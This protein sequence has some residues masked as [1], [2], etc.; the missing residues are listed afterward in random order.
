M[1]QNLFV[2]VVEGKPISN[3]EVQLNMDVMATGLWDVQPFLLLV[4]LA[5]ALDENLLEF[6][7]RG[8]VGEAGNAVMHLGEILVDAEQALVLESTRF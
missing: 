8:L 5:Q 7:R 6:L 2:K 3:S 1:L 4:Q